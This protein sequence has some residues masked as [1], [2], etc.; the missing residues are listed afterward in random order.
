MN[1]GQKA[2]SK[3]KEFE[4]KIESILSK[5]YQ[6]VSKCR[7]WALQVLRQPIFS[8]Q[9]VIG[10]NL[11]GHNCK[12]DFILYHPIRWPNSLVLE[13]KWQKSGGSVEAKF[14][15]NVLTIKMNDFDTIIVLDG[16]GYTDG[17]E[18]WLRQQ[19]GKDKLKHVFTQEQLEKFQNQGRL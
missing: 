10:K 8:K 17:A 7:F 14:P 16:G 11:Y 3:G 6:E 4:E 15:F 13:V 2:N 1:K 12:V 19:V 5:E 18:Y 9:C